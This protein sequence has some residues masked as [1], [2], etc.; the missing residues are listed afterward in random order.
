M[1]NKIVGRYLNSKN[2]KAIGYKFTAPHGANTVRKK[3][4]NYF[5]DLLNFIILN[6]K[7]F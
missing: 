1:L 7:L 6:K 4:L 5:H 2:S 3:F